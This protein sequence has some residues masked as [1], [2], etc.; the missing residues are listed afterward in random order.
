[1]NALV[2]CVATA[3]LGWQYG[4]ERLPDGGMRYVIQLDRASLAAL[5]D[6]Q[7]IES[8]I[9]K[10]I[11]EHV[12]SLR[13]T[14]GTGTPRRDLPPLALPPLKPRV[15]EK[16]PEL[17]PAEKPNPPAEKPAKQPETP[18]KPWL[19]LTFT[20]LALAASLGANCFQGWIIWGYRRR[21]QSNT[22][23]IGR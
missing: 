21:A 8:D 16:P 9:P 14:V 6:Y 20:F 19:P 17:P 7:P 11:V 1:M 12:R 18:A 13:I 2:F 22:S 23:N 3:A 10:E 5:R 4:Y 15:V